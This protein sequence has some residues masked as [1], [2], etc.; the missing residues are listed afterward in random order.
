M[1]VYDIKVS[2][3]NTKIEIKLQLPEYV[4]HFTLDKTE[5]IQLYCTK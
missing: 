4:L 2:L 5:F 1:V 3:V